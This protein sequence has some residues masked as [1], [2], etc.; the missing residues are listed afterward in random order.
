MGI[1]D[2][3]QQICPWRGCGPECGR[4]VACWTKAEKH[5]DASEYKTLLIYST[6]GTLPRFTHEHFALRPGKGGSVTCA[7]KAKP[8]LYSELRSFYR[9]T[10]KG[11]PPWLS[12]KQIWYSDLGKMWWSLISFW[13]F[14]EM[15]NLGKEI[16]VRWKTISLRNTDRYDPEPFSI[17]FCVN[18]CCWRTWWLKNKTNKKYF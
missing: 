17:F 6:C 8:G 7:R 10:V 3:C 14:L 18:T 13:M 15:K 9:T 2:L 12:L 4:K 1:P 11:A 5:L 16:R